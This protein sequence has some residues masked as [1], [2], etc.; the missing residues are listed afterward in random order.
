M[1][2]TDDHGSHGTPSG[3]RLSA[4]P[5]SS[6]TIVK[7]AR[8]RAR[9]AEALAR[10]RV[11]LGFVFGAVVLWLAQPTR[12]T[13]A[14]GT[15]IA[16]GGE[17]LRIWASGH[18]NKGRDVTMSGPYRWLAHPLYVGS[19][20]LGVGL[21]AIA[22]H[23]VV[24]GLIALYLVVTISAAVSRE[25]AFLRRTFGDRY[26][27]YRRGDDGGEGRRRF[28]VAQ[29]IANHEHRAIIGLAVAVLL[30]LLKATYNGTF[31]R[32]AGPH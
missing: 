13:L 16:A 8:L 5:G 18:L 25:E 23:F 21:A 15:A 14:I 19:S 4:I 6:A 20:I 17:C 32:A 2:A 3:K 27:R 24:T 12:E 30:L 7:L 26:D 29:A 11:P 10:R 9:L 28:S 1:M 22:D 31:W